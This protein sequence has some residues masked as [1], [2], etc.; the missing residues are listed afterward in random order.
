VHHHFPSISQAPPQQLNPAVLLDDLQRKVIGDAS[1]TALFN[2]VRQRQSIELLRYHYPKVYD[3]PFNS[4][5]KYA[6]TVVKSVGVA[7]HSVSKRT[8]LMKG[9][10]EV[11]LGRCSHYMRRGARLSID[12]TF[13][14]DFEEAYERFGNLGQ[15]VL[16]FAALDLPEAQFGQAFDD[17]YATDSDK[18]P[19]TGLVFVGLVSLV[20]PPKESVPQ[21]VLD[22]QQAG[23][24]VIMVTGGQAQELQLH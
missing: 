12:E 5:N 10:P 9:A 16:G 19:T 3:V 20:D 18:V 8:L 6:L 17:R 2:F 24:Q 1:E 22:A 23:I 14:A 4:R 15:R 11:V 21:A 7:G 13:R